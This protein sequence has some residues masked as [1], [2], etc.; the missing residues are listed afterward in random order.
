MKAPVISKEIKDAAL[1][2]GREWFDANPD[3]DFNEKNLE[4]LFREL[5]AAHPD[6]K[7]GIGFPRET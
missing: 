7:L 2:K 6:K 1:K 3:L 5:K 4:S